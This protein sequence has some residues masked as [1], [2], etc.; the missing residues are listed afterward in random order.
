MTEEKKTKIIELVKNNKID[1]ALFLLND[2]ILYK[3]FRNLQAHNRIG[4]ISREDYSLESNQITKAILDSLVGSLEDMQ[5]KAAHDIWSNWMRYF[6]T[7]GE[8]NGDGSF[9]IPKEK[10]ERWT[11]QMNTEFEDLSEKEKQSDYEIAEQ[12]IEPLM[13]PPATG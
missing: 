3:R 8:Y 7:Q 4:I 5:A 10:V 9:T 12:F 1:N 11:R 13:V 2:P 6:F